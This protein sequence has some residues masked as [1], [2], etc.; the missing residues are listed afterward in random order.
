M[1]TAW[2]EVFVLTLSECVA[3]AGKT[4]CEQQQLQMQFVDQAECEMALQQML[5]LK[6]GADNVIVYKDKSYCAPS[7]AQRP[8]FKSLNEVN[9]KLAGSPNWSAPQV[10]EAPVDFIRSS[11]EERLASLHN[12]EDVSGVAP[13]KIGDIIIEG[14]SRQPVEVWRRDN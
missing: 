12:C 1:D 10:D 4:V 11:H 9:E 14:A 13:C 6:E 2:I 7:A 3:P 8:I 5:T